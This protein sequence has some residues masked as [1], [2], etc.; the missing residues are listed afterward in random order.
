ME[1]IDAIILAGGLGTRL[2]T[3]IDDRP[4]VLAPVNNRPFLD[5]ILDTLS[6]CHLIGRVILA[7]GYMAE[8]IMEEYGQ[9]KKYPFEISFS[10][11]ET[12][13]GTGGGIKKA[14]PLTTT[15]RVLVLNGDSFV[16]VDFYELFRFNKENRA[17]MAVTVVEV[18]NTSRFGRVVLGE[19][20]RIVSFQEKS[21]HEEA[22]YINAGVYLFQKNLFNDVAGDIPVSL[23]HDLIPAFMRKGV[24]GFV[25]KG[26][27]IDMG[28]PESY[29]AADSLFKEAI[30][31]KCIQRS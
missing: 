6:Q 7:V 23:E 16:D 2:R 21:S 19:E 30:N 15:K 22:G 26:K 31:D 17:S 4:K 28:T 3:V 20:G 18:D 1:K 14:L 25:T 24:Y 13:L 12:P 29:S 8:K 5:I 9:S 27:F 11:E 10:I